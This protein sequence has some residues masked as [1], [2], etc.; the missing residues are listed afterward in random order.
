MV[1]IVMFINYCKIKTLPV[2]SPPLFRVYLVRR[3]ECMYKKHLGKLL[4]ANLLFFASADRS[5]V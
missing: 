4:Y 3:T 2:V 1:P 5:L